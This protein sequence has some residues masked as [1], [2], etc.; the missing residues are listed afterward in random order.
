MLIAVS[1][2]KIIRRLARQFIMLCQLALAG[3]KPERGHPAR[4]RAWHAKFCIARD[5]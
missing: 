3:M 4:Q 2:T 1:N 5:R